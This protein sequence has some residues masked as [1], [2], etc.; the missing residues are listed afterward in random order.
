MFLLYNSIIMVSINVKFF[1]HFIFIYFPNC[2]YV[3]IGKLLYVH[4]VLGHIEW[5]HW[6]HTII[7]RKYERTRHTKCVFITLQKWFDEQY[8]HFGSSWAIH[9][10]KCKLT[11][12]IPRCWH[13]LP[14][15]Q[16]LDWCD[17]FTHMDEY[18]Q[19]IFERYG[20]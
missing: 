19:Y 6:F 17:N 9:L 14:L 12:A 7:L 5:D 20:I 1:F 16:V 18:F 15:K 8:N 3:W 13:F 10:Y 2:S 11:W 4:H